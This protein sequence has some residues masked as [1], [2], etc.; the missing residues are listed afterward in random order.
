ML[1]LSTS[2][3]SCQ[4]SRVWARSLLL[5][6]T[7][8]GALLLGACTGVSPT[9]AP[10]AAVAS[11]STAAAIASLSTAAASVSAAPAPAGVASAPPVPTAASVPPVSTAGLVPAVRAPVRQPPT[12]ALGPAWQYNG[13]AEAIRGALMLTDAATTWSAGSA[14]WKHE[15][16][17]PKVLTVSFDASITGG[18]GA[19]GLTLAVVDATKTKPTVLGKDGGGL[20]WAGIPGFAIALDTFQDIGDPSYNTVGLVDGFD[21]L[22]LDRLKWVAYSTTAPSLRKQTRHIVA[23]VTGDLLKVTVDGSPTFQAPVS[24]PPRMLVGFT[25]GNGR[26]SELQVVSNIHIAVT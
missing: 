9:P 13:T 3:R 1:R 4:D 22:H 24:L 7:C 6:A 16:K 19:D 17:N 15:F 20:G 8:A 23:T 2:P 12:P 14:F 11:V 5:S 21:P 10:A 26:R 18:T 25:A